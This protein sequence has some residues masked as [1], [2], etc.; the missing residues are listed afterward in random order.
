M[1]FETM[2]RSRLMM[3]LPAY[4]QQIEALRI[5]ALKDLLRAYGFTANQRDQVRAVEGRYSS[6]VAELESDCA[7]IEINVARLLTNVVTAR[8]GV[9]SC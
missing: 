3:Q 4:R 7:R 9:G 6:H 1:D 8:R 2:G 5:P